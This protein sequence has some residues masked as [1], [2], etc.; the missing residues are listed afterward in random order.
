MSKFSTFV[1]FSFIFSS[2]LFAQHVKKKITD[3]N[4]PWIT[5]KWEGDSMGNHYYDKAFI[6]IPVRIDDLPYNFD[7]QFDLGAFATMIYGKSIANYTNFS[8]SLHESGDTLQFRGRKFPL[9]KNV[10]LHLD[11]ITFPDLTIV[12]LPGFGSEIPLDSVKT[13]SV[14]HIG[15]VGVDLCANKVLIID[16][17]HQRISIVNDLPREMEAETDFLPAKFN[18]DNRVMIPFT[19]GHKTVYLMFDTGSSTFPIITYPKYAALITNPEEP[20]TDSLGV[21]SWGAIHQMYKKKMNKQLYLGKTLIKNNYVFYSD[22][23]ASSQKFFDE[24]DI[25]G[26]T[27]NV[28]FLDKVLVIDFKNKKFGMLKSKAAS[29]GYKP[30]RSTPGSIY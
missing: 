14:K 2:G 15:T 22:K 10:T 6:N 17:P 25:F 27:G 5:F 21:S 8:P 13:S 30:G 26:F 11:K 18:K 9:L 12:K 29:I 4:I 16:Y 19:I 24:N 7:A 1:L 23:A 3:E 20:V 28:L